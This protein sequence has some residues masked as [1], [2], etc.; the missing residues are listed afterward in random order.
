MN[1]K[2][3]TAAAI[4]IGALTTSK[5]SL[6]DIFS[7]KTPHNHIECMAKNIYFE[8][9]SQ[10]LVGQLAVGLVVLNRVKSKHFPDDVCE[11]VYQGP[12]KESWKTKKYPNLPKELRKYYQENYK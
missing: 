4:I 2:T 6:G 12:V 3:F 7:G 5:I 8:A 1:S 11:V 10:S 9:K